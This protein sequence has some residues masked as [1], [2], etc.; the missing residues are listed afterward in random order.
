MASVACAV[1]ASDALA[2]D[3]GSPGA[4]ALS[5]LRQ[6]GI[7]LAVVGSRGRGHGCADGHG[8]SRDRHHE[9][10]EE[11][12]TPGV[13][14]NPSGHHSIRRVAYGVIPL[15]RTGETLTTDPV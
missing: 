4:P 11:P 5:N 12:K 14:S 15:V 1:A 9:A 6:G 10:A 13:Q 3:S 7:P 2:M 8:E